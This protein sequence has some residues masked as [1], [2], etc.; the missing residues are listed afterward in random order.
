MREH[1]RK[2]HNLQLGLANIR[3]SAV[4][5]QS[6]RQCQYIHKLECRFVGSPNACLSN[7]NDVILLYKSVRYCTVLF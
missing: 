5:L 4:K 2:E 6:A 7:N 3:Q 1:T